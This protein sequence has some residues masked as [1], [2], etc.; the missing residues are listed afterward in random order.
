MNGN[1]TVHRSTVE[2]CA[3]GESFE[4][5]LISKEF[6]LH[7]LHLDLLSLVLSTKGCYG[8]YVNLCLFCQFSISFEIQLGH[9]MVYTLEILF[10]LSEE[11]C[12][13]L[14]SQL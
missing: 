4:M 6:I 14:F 11:R 9:I 10:D 1:Q 2:F 8:L 3:D 13:Q 7:L 5:I 12:L